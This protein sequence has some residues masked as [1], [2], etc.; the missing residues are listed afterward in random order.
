MS[1]NL[2]GLFSGK[3]DSTK[4]RTV[5]LNGDRLRNFRSYTATMRLELLLTGQIIFTEAQF[6]DGLYFHWLAHNS[7]EFEAFNKLMLP[8]QDS[9]DG[10]DRLFSIAVKCR[11]PEGNDSGEPYN[12][13]LILDYALTKMY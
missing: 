1:E 11:Y 12:Q 5:L 9:R 7:S 6:F 10:R 3:Y 8:F 4:Q 2:Y 13:K